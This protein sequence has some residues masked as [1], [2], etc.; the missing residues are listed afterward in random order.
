MMFGPGIHK[1]NVAVPTRHIKQQMKKTILK[2]TVIALLLMAAAVVFT[3]V[4]SAQDARNQQSPSSALQAAL[5]EKP[6]EQVRKNVKAL[7]GMPQSQFFPTMVFFAGSLGVDCDFCHA[8]KNGQIDYASD[9]KREKQT[10][11]EMIRM[12]RDINKT[13]AQGNPT[14]SCY[15]CHRG[16]TSPQGF[17]SLPLPVTAAPSRPEQSISTD[18]GP[19][20]SAEEVINKYIDA[21]GGQARINRLKTFATKGTR[22]SGGFTGPYETEQSAP[23]MGY[24]WFATP[25]GKLERAISGFRGW[26]KG[27][28]GIRE[29]VGEQVA[30]EKMSLQLFINLRLKDQYSQLTVAGRDKLRDRDVFIV[31][32]TRL[33]NRRERLYFDVAN[34]LLLR[35]VSYTQTMIGIIPQQVDFD[36]YRSVEGVN[37]PFKVTVAT[38]DPRSP[39]T[40][41]TLQEV[42]ANVPVSES[43]FVRPIN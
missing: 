17:P 26:E 34:G 2:L 37:F 20:P 42:R 27:P 30:D 13:Y 12:V 23:D 39:I 38:V 5:P 8:S 24:E 4:I 21:I 33:D 25:N 6:A 10:A 19:L 28:E 18:G 29:F 16:H 32:A 41:R 3:S 36:D 31:R 9:D 15:T 1:A 40:I 35:R 14:V 11:R 7:T 22:V 43:T